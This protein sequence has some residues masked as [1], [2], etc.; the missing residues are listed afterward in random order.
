MKQFLL[1]KEN[2]FFSWIFPAILI[3]AFTAAAA[4]EL[5]M[6]LYP[7][8]QSLTSLEGIGWI[9]IALA[10]FSMKAG[11]FWTFMSLWAGIAILTTLL[12]VT[13]RTMF[14]AVVTIW[15]S[16]FPPKEPAN[17]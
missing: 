13:G 8:A 9:V 16:I 15:Q 10:K 11:P 7:W 4:A 1:A 17:S 5:Q 12:Y 2:A 6:A 3:V 14:V